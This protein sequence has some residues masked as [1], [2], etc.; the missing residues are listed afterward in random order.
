MMK[1]KYCNEKTV[2]NGVKF[3]SKKESLYARKLDMLTKAVSMEGHQKIELNP[4]W[5]RENG[6]TKSRL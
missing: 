1:S 6:F 4:N 3:D 2:Y 5:A